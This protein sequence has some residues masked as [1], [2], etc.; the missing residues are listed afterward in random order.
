MAAGLA[1]LGGKYEVLARLG[2]G[3]MGE[4]YLVRHRHLEQARVVKV[5]R[6]EL[7]A[8]ADLRERF[9]REAR[10]ASRI[11]H[12]RIARLHDFEVAPD[13]SA[14]LVLEHV[15][16]YTLAELAALPGP[17][18]LSAAAVA[19][20]GLAV[21]EAL[22]HLHA[23]GFLHRD[24]SPDNVMAFLD[25]R[26][27]A[28]VKLIDLGIAKAL[29]DSTAI[30]GT[31]GDAF[32]G[33][34]LYASPEQIR[35]DPLGPASDFYSLGAML[36]QLATGR[37]P[38]RYGNLASLLAAHL[39][40][41][42]LPFEESDPS[43]RVPAPL[44]ALLLRLL[45]KDPERR[46][47]SADKLA[48]G[49]A[50]VSGDAGPAALAER[51]RA[52]AAALGARDAGSRAD[53]AAHPTLQG[54]LDARFRGATGGGAAEVSGV[55]PTVIFAERGNASPQTATPRPVGSAPLPDRPPVSP[56]A[57]WVARTGG[58]VPW[59]AQPRGRLAVAGIAGG[60]AFF[61]LFMLML[62][63]VGR[64]PHDNPWQAVLYSFPENFRIDLGL[65]GNGDWRE[66]LAMQIFSITA[67]LPGLAAGAAGALVR[68]KGWPGW[69]GLLLSALAAFLFLAPYLPP[70]GTYYRY[71]P[72]QLVAVAYLGAGAV[73]GR[74]GAWLDAALD[75]R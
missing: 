11:E 10:I 62:W 23:A 5:M 33:K 6:P 16:G 55:A 71:E 21:T 64:T 48:I 18:P 49:L 68:R 59:L 9:L 70:I 35:T 72:F 63:I 34:P 15:P 32:L 65:Y 61:V 25:E 17:G 1:S 44:R 27:A 12:P 43:G 39:Q 37:F 57:T 45:D 41:A 66:K 51:V 60:A 58:R 56:V 69:L 47:D 73:A 28:G 50:L 52:A 20:L 3:G 4:T 29:K 30:S 2:G 13:G 19:E 14:F 67:F 31:R 74:L 42:P 75:R 22:Q 24:V 8:D 38:Y 7:T 46:L 53:G 40:G 36:Y 54:E 26:G